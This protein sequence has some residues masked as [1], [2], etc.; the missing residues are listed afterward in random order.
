MIA[1]RGL[2]SYENVMPFFP[3]LLRR[4]N[5]RGIEFDVHQN[6]KGQMV[7]THNYVDRDRMSSDLFRN[8]PKVYGKAKMVVDIKTFN[9]DAVYM[10][11]N[12]V[13]D[14]NYIDQPIHDWHLCSFN[15]RCV[16]ELMTLRN[17]SDIDFKIGYIYHGFVGI[18]T[19]LDIDFISLN[20]KNIT[21]TVLKKYHKKGIKVYAWTVPPS[22]I[23]RLIEM[24]VDAI[25]TDIY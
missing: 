13:N 18:R 2:R 14:L 1:H 8:F 6:S 23:D 3:V 12:V 4:P 24:G 5:I 19:D 20:Y 17:E 16:H 25:I 15:E 10:A 21:K 7:V 11:N 22:E 9:K